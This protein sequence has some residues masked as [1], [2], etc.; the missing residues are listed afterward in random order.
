MTD[1][2]PKSVSTY[3]LALSLHQCQFTLGAMAFQ[4]PENQKT[5]RAFLDLVI[6]SLGK[7]SEG[8]SPSSSGIH[9]E[10]NYG[11]D[12]HLETPGSSED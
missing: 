5:Y 4:G 6:F 3:I 7:L 11:D 2:S 8:S 10:E 9:F 12:F 1:V